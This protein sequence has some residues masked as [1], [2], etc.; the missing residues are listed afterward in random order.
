MS[1]TSEEIALACHEANRALCLA[2]GDDTQKPWALAER[3]QRDS[4]KAQMKFI[5]ENPQ[6]GVD[7]THISWS[8]EK[9]DGG[10][11]F[12]E[13]KDPAKKTHPCLVPFEDLPREQQAKDYIFRAI[14]LALTD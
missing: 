6:A 7:A 14:V 1:I 2:F 3:W 12:G 13:T 8:E 10:W 4:T 5:Q 11:V 9:L